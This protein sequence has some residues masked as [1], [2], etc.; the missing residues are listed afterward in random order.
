MPPSEEAGL[1]DKEPNGMPRIHGR[2]RPKRTGPC[3]GR[4]DIVRAQLAPAPCMAADARGPPWCQQARLKAKE[5]HKL[6]S[7]RMMVTCIALDK[8][9][10]GL[11]FV[12]E[13]TVGI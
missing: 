7:G 4:G 8:E 3:E 12:P 2:P 5:P 1:F 10:F 13:E 11:V 6:A 9:P